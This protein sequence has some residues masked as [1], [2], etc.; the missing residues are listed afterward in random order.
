MH[1]G[2]EGG[3]G[4][5]LLLAHGVEQVV[6]AALDAALDVPI[7]LAVTHEVEP[8]LGE[9]GA[10]DGREIEEGQAQE[11]AL[12]GA[13]GEGDGRGEGRATRAR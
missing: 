3:E 10:G 6:G 12:V 8:H 11:T 9:G 4:G 5:C 7:R 1:L 2:E 13:E